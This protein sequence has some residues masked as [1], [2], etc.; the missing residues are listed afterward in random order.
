MV[1]EAGASVR[2]ENKA[3]ERGEAAATEAEQNMWDTDDTTRL[4]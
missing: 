4:S 1:D 2:S 3:T